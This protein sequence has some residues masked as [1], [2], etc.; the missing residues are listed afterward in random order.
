MANPGP[1]NMNIEQ[2]AN[3]SMSSPKLEGSVFKAKVATRHRS[4]M[5][6]YIAA[7]NDDGVIDRYFNLPEDERTTIEK[8]RGKEAQH[9]DKST[10]KPTTWEKGCGLGSTVATSARRLFKKTKQ[11]SKQRVWFASSVDM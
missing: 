3:N 5:A 6:A 2:R 9:S 4:R 10:A 8:S 1:T 7:M 11:G